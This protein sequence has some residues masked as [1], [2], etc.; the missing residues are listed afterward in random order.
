MKSDAIKSQ[1]E[2]KIGFPLDSIS[3]CRRLESLMKVQ[4]IYVSYTTLSRI[5]KL[6]QISASARE[7]TLNELSKFL[8]YEN[9][10]HFS[11]NYSENEEMNRQRVISGLEIEA[12]LISNQEKKAIDY[13]ISLRE[14]HPKLY[15]YHSQSICKHLFDQKSDGYNGLEYLKTYDKI[16]HEIVQHFVYEDDPHGRYNQFVEQLILENKDF[17]DLRPFHNLYAARK[18]ILKNNTT[19]KEIEIN[20]NE[21]FHLTSRRFELELL[22]DQLTDQQIK[23]RTQFILSLIKVESST[24]L[25]FAYA[26]RWCRGL[27]MTNKNNLLRNDNSWKN[28]CEVLMQTN[29]FT[30]EFQVIIYCFLLSTYNV[31]SSLDF[32]YRGKWDNANLESNLHFSKAFAKYD[33][34]TI[35]KKKLGYQ[36]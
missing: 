5:F 23:E 21:H 25:S 15:M 8:G 35:F 9:F 29:D 28:A 17:D 36:Y 26:G 20:S 4:G 24:E 2:K 7:S 14:K 27:L 22:L 30:L 18:E 3:S 12:Y 31:Q 13:W 19:R 1:L 11:L 32:M 34:H 6:A 10:Y 16:A 33:A